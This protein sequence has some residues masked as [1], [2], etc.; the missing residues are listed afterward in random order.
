MKECI[1]CQVIFAGKKK[2]KWRKERE[3]EAT[4]NV[5]LNH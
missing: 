1:K 2:R 3:S 4:R 5:R